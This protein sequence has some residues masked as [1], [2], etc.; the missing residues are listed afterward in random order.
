[1]QDP[2]LIAPQ[3]E[4]RPAPPLPP[5]H[6]PHEIPPHVFKELMR[7]NE[8]I[9]KLEGMMEMLIKQRACHCDKQSNT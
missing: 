4:E 9:G 7:M 8:K 6:K 5:P 1:M 3:S 2:K